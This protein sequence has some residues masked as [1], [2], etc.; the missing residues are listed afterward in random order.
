MSEQLPPE[1][2]ATARRPRKALIALLIIAGVLVVALIVLIV[3][4]VQRDGANPAPSPT[5]TATATTTATPT[6]R[7]TSTPTTRPTGTTTPTSVVSRCTVGQLSVTLGKGN[8]AAGSEIVPIIFT[9]TAKVACEL[10]GF[11][12]VS[13]VGNG[14]GTQLGAAADE[15][16]AIAIQQNTLQPEAA[17]Q[18]KLKITNAGNFGN[19]TTANADG[20]RVYPPHS[21]QAVFVKASGL[22]ACTNSD[23]HLLSV[24]PVLAK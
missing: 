16:T 24:Q 12:G 4:L 15:D 11:P 13:F 17:V 6:V 19:C 20:L 1:P 9:N 10:H 7:P 8:G 22:T 2:D 5:T 14:N 21:Y 23:V 18:A 3:L